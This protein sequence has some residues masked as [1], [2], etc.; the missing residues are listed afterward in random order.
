MPP[1][2]SPLER[3]L[4]E[5]REET[6]AWNQSFWARQ[7]T[8]FQRVSPAPL[9]GSVGPGWAGWGYVW[10]RGHRPL[11]RALCGRAVCRACVWVRAAAGS[12][13]AAFLALP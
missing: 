1:H 11:L 7:N 6:Q 3:R 8:A 9:G 4:R 2:E 12:G 5:L 13:A 10:L